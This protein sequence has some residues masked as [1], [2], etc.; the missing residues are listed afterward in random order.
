M[1]GVNGIIDK[2]YESNECKVYLFNIMQNAII[3]CI[4][5]GHSKVLRIETPHF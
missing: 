3:R 2:F 1:G 4:K 5:K